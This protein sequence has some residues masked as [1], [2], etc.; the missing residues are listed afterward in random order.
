MNVNS[1]SGSNWFQQL[2]TKFMAGV[3]TAAATAETT[4]TASAVSTALSTPTD[5][6][7]TSPPTGA[8]SA[9]SN[10]FAPDT[11]IA[12]ISAQASPPTSDQVAQGL[13][14][15]LDMDGSGSLSLS[16]ISSALS[17][18]SAGAAAN[19]TAA[20]GLSAAFA[21]MD[22]NGDGQ[23]SAGELSA[24]LST[25]A[26]EASAQGQAG[27]QGAG[28]GHHHHHHHGGGSSQ[29]ANQT[30][31]STTGASS[32]AAIVDPF[33]TD[34]RVGVHDGDQLIGGQIRRRSSHAAVPL[35]TGRAYPD[36]RRDAAIGGERPGTGAG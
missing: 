5:P 36:A 10:Q 34:A 21:K 19:A 26:Q 15:A 11:L 1:L 12:L 17:D 18:P 25:A 9:P 28:G 29:A 13:I 35:D 8:P 23:L 32:A 2:E 27:A 33:D 30:G 20:S 7:T 3:Q 22:T 6:S 4:D 24:A 14:S 31:S 16:E